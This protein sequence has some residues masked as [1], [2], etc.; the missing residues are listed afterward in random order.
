MDQMCSDTIKLYYLDSIYMNIG[1]T[2]MPATD[3]FYRNFSRTVAT[4]VKILF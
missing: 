1:S 4:L 2:Y 3:F